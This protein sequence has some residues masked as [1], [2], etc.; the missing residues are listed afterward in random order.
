MK[1]KLLATLVIT[2]SIALLG[3]CATPS[4]ITMKDG[5]VIR[6]A[7]S[8]KFDEDTGFYQFEILE[9]GHPN[10]INKDEIISIEPLAD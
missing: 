7:D 1:S 2:G 6:T 10:S 5:T 4:Q 9:T 3:G 8:P